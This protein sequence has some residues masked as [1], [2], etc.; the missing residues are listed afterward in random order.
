MTKSTPLPDAI[1]TRIAVNA[2]TDCW[3]WTGYVTSDKQPTYRSATTNVNARRYLYEKHIGPIPTRWRLV[4]PCATQPCVN[5]KHQQPVKPGP[6]ERP[7]ADRFWSKVDKDGPNGCWVWLGHLNNAGYGTAYV[8]PDKPSAYAHRVSYS[9]LV[10]DLPD[11]I[12]VDHV[13]HN[14]ACLN[15]DHLRTATHALNSEN[16]SGPPSS[17][18]SGYLGVYF[19]ERSQRWMAQVRYR[20]QN[21]LSKRFKSKEEA[22]EAARQARLEHF[23]YNV[24]DRAS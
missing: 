13:C 4:N 18:K 11:H 20:G 15:P 14:P 19:E 10:E 17:N 9:L 21:V 22:A 6:K 5:P 24:R 7:L 1:N 12:E 2:D 8:S 3:V 23:T 16:R